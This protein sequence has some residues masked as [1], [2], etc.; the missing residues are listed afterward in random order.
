MYTYSTLQ[1][2]Q[3]LSQIKAIM[4]NFT[5]SNHNI[6]HAIDIRQQVDEKIPK[7]LATRNEADNTACWLCL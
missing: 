7:T 1:K 6:K 5:T 2:L 4:L 3:Q